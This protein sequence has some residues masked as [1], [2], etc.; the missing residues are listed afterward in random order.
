MTEAMLLNWAKAVIRN[1]QNGQGYIRTAVAPAVLRLIDEKDQW[2]R[3]AGKVQ[4]VSN[5]S[6]DADQT[7]SV[8]HW[9]P[10]EIAPC[11]V[12]QVGDPNDWSVAPVETAPASEGDEMMAFF[13]K[14]NS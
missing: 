10:A 13:K 6:L 5:P 4:I 7:T 2:Q 9:R 14:T 8:Y 11:L 3:R 1:D 12:S